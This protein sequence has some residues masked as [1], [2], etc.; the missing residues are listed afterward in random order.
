MA[1]NIGEYD[2]LIAGMAGIF[3]DVAEASGQGFES[4]VLGRPDFERLE[5]QALKI[6]SLAGH[7]EKLR[8]AIMPQVAAPA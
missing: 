7:L 5:V 2:A 6:G 8:E 3:K 4:P 1:K